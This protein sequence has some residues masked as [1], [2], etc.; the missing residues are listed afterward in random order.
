MLRTLWSTDT[1]FPKNTNTLLPFAYAAIFLLAWTTAYLLGRLPPRAREEPFAD[2]TPPL[3]T[4][5]RTRRL[6]RLLLQCADSFGNPTGNDPGWCF[7]T[8][9]SRDFHPYLIGIGPYPSPV[10]VLNTLHRL[11]APLLPALVTRHGG[12]AHVTN[13]PGA[14]TATRLLRT[15]R[16][17][18]K[19]KIGQLHHPGDCEPFEVPIRLSRNKEALQALVDTGA[20]GYGFIDAS[21]AKARGYPLEELATPRHLQV[22]DGR[23]IASGAITH[24]CKLRLEMND[25]VEGASLFVTK[26]GETKVVLGLPWLQHHAPEIRFADRSISFHAERCQQ[27]TATLW[28]STLTCPTLTA[29][30][31]TLPPPP[32]P[33]R[34]RTAIPSRPPPIPPRPATPRH[35]TTLPSPKPR[36]IAVPINR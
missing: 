20:T 13:A 2:Q 35:T 28:T 4:P 17:G 6:Q 14:H 36:L 32:I 5:R 31:A 27:H 24:C 1:L 11:G 33:P 19:L 23:A 29:S 9:T 21:F 18:A 10:K 26:L 3:L 15:R 34:P 30:A 16:V 7:L 12:T 22:I 25:H 8:L